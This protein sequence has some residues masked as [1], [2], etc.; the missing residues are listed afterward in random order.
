MD[1]NLAALHSGT[2]ALGIRHVLCT[3][4]R[5]VRYVDR[6]DDKPADQAIG[7]LYL[8]SRE[9][10][11]LRSASSRSALETLSAEAALAIENARLYREALD[12]AKFEQELKVAAAI[13]RSLLPAA[14]IKGAFFAATGSSSPCLAVGGDFFDYVDLPTGQFGFIVGDVAGK[15]SPAALLAAAVLGMF[16]AESTYQMSPAAVMSRLNRG[17]FRRAIEN[18]FLTAFYGLLGP[19][20]AFTF[21]NAGHNAPMLVTAS[22]VKRLETGGL[23]LG[24]FEHA[25]FEEETVSLRPGD[26][27]VAFSDGVTEALDVAGEEYMDERLL[28]SIERHRSLIQNPEALLEGLLA[29]VKIF[30]G[31]ATPNDDLTVVMVRFDG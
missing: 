29:D 15:G 7:V 13:Q 24:L 12:K 11:A 4:L 31:A 19:D 3:P 14:S 28:A 21:S 20:G 5:I 25:T 1:D 26:F 18:R 23:V 27:I 6:A 8:D 17:L 10:G 2:V 9:R 16:S 30:C 22:G